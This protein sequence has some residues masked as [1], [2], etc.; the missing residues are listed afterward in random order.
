MFLR[1]VHVEECIS[2][3]FLLV[4]E[5]ST[6]LDRL[7]FPYPSNEQL[8]IQLIDTGVISFSGECSMNDAL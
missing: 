7:H 1:F 4:A 6:V 2:D 5:C 8:L 3:S